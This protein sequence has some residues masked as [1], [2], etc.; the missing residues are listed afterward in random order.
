MSDFKISK[1]N[2]YVCVSGYGWTGSSACVDILKEF[3]GFGALQGEF[4]ITKDP[5]G[6]NDLENS[7]VHNWDFVRHDVAIR[8]FL[9]YSQVL[10]RDIGV[11]S[12]VGKGFSNKLSIDL[13]S[14]SILY[15]DRLVNMTY[16]GDTFVHRYKISAYKNFIANMRNKFGKNN[17]KLMYFARPDI[18]DFIRETREYID[19]LFDNYMDLEKINTLILDQAVSPTNIIGTSKYFK[20]V[21]VIIIDRDPRDIYTNMVKRK[22]LLGSELSNKDSAEKYIKWHKKLRQVST[23]DKNNVD[24]DKHVLRIYF[25]D[26]VLNHD[27][28]I[29]KIMS[30]LGGRVQHNNKGK[31]FSPE[32]SIDNIRLW[33]SYPDQFVMDKIA[34]ELESSCYVG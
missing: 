20:D 33:K 19:S 18:G 32:D 34:E 17:E 9:V 29:E 6:L 24:L 8:D 30:F 27:E 12:Q 13:M 28:F 10:S 4:R 5:Y 14:K 3:E 26:L 22:R 7:L 25:E 23:T 21:K 1:N 2:N 16:L 15:I 31:Y 11:F